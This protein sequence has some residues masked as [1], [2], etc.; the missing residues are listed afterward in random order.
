[1]STIQPGYAYKGFIYQPEEDREDDNV[2]IFHFVYTELPSQ[3]MIS[4]DWSPYSTPSAEQFQTWVDLGMPKRI[5]NGPLDGNDLIKIMA[6]R[7]E[8]KRSKWL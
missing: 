1:M 6:D 2:K 7:A 3:K 8:A 4:M 5:T